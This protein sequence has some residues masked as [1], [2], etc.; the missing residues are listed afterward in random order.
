[1]QPYKGVYDLGSKVPFTADVVNLDD[2]ESS[3]LVIDLNSKAMENPK[4]MS[5]SPNEFLD[6]MHSSPYVNIVEENSLPITP[7]SR[8]E[9]VC[10]LNIVD[11]K[12]VSKKEEE[13]EDTLISERDGGDWS[14]IC[15]WSYG[16]GC[17]NALQWAKLGTPSPLK[18]FRDGQR[19]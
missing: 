5:R 8:R 12:V 2:Y 9:W 18:Y 1:M 15:K 10:K 7:D 14:K 11:G 4:L 19:S 6:N 16:L 3:R 17:G 13:E